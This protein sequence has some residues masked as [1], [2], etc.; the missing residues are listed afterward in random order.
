[1]NNSKR[2]NRPWS[3]S[4]ETT[5]SSPRTLRKRPSSTPKNRSGKQFPSN[6]YRSTQKST[7]NSN[8]YRSQETISK[9]NTNNTRKLNRKELNYLQ[10]V[11][12]EE[13]EEQEELRYSLKHY[14]G[15]MSPDIAQINRMVKELRLGSM[16]KT[17]MALSFLQDTNLHDE[18]NQIAVIQTGGDGP[19]LGLLGSDNYKLLSASLTILKRII[20]SQYNFIYLKMVE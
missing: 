10:D 9:Q 1:M 16:N 2:K 3:L 12:D 11:S 17:I 5:V 18:K 15:E 13:G 7:K 19:L 20:K 4:T 6:H 14:K 8:N